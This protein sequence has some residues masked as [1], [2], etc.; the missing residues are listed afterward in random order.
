MD[1]LF[2]VVPHDEVR[3]RS[4]E[5]GAS[6]AIKNIDDDDEKDV[7]TTQVEKVDTKKENV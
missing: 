4:G 5:L 2:G 7:A 6:M 1:A 3:L